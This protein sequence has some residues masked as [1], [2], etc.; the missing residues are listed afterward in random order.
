M[1]TKFK[2]V[3][4]LPP[5]EDMQEF[6]GGYV[7]GLRL[8]NGHTLYVNEEGRLKGLP[9]NKMATAFWSAS[10]NTQSKI[11]GNVIYHINKHD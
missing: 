7:E 4:E 1:K 10:Y 8:K 2:T 9:V 11:V 3:T 6:V 5:L